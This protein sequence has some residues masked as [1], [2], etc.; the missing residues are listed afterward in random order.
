MKQILSI[1][2]LMLVVALIAITGC[3]STSM[4]P[5]EQDAASKTFKAPSSNMAGLYIYRNSS[6]GAALLKTVSIDNNI[7]GATAAKTY[8]HREISPGEHT[9]A[10]QSEWSDNQLN[11]N[12]E[13]GKNYFIHQY[14][15]IG[16]LVGGAGLESVTEAEG[17]K[18]VLECNEAL[19]LTVVNAPSTEPVMATTPAA[20]IVAVSASNTI[21]MQSESASSKLR[22]LNALYKEGVINQ[23]EFETKKQEILKSM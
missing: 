11:V 20:Q 15:K 3:A 5:K 22:D 14:I 21:P 4:A 10:T 17:Q 23:H 9:L 18:G 16:V 8:F 6:F 13:A 19:S 2:G 12:T 7:I 1:R